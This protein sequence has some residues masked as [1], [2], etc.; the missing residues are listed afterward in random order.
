MP[1]K[2]I[3]IAILVPCLVF[4]FLEIILRISNFEVNT[5]KG[6]I[7]EASFFNFEINK[8]KED[9][10][11]FIETG[12]RIYPPGY[13][14][15]RCWNF[16]LNKSVD[17]FRILT[18][19]DSCT[20]GLGVDME[21]TFPYFLEKQ[22]GNFINKSKVRIFNFGFP[23]YTSFQGLLF[24]KRYIKLLKPDLLIVWF[25]ANDACFAPFFSDK[26]FYGQRN[27]IVGLVKI[28][29]ILYKHSKLYRFL[30]NMNLYYFRKLVDRSF[31]YPV[32]KKCNKYRV[33]SED[34]LLNLD[35]MKKICKDY[36][37]KILFIWHC[38][39]IDGKLFRHQGYKPLRP[40]IDL[41]KI[42]SPISE[43]DKY[44][45]THC[46]AA[47]LGHLLIARNIAE[48]IFGMVNISK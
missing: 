19:G 22:L 12:P 9:R 3:I 37:C 41:Y 24:L 29:N 16:E 39:Y 18:L 4:I 14:Q 28:H 10:D 13:K 44:F 46:H 31:N 30:K 8:K 32:E 11:I 2:K 25:G 21:E 47:K 17:E 40:Y 27:N 48:E 36:H 26:E 42:Y 15:Y 33:S 45:L 1:Y 5:G 6:P 38:W 43:K 35:Q 34:F 20:Y 23:G 7:E